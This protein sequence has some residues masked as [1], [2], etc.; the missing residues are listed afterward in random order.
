M[1]LL[2]L[3]FYFLSTNVLKKNSET[4]ICD[5]KADG[6]SFAIILL[7]LICKQAFDEEKCEDKS[8]RIP[9]VWASREYELK[10]NSGFQ[11]IDCPLVHESLK[12]E[13]V[14]FWLPTNYAVWTIAKENVLIY[15]KFISMCRV[16]NFS[17]GI[18]VW[19]VY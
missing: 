13:P 7:G 19:K 14:E 18:L 6:F 16:Y 3:Q 2:A 4:G 8:K 12:G 1:I 17:L 9:H 10:L 5:Q 15:R 11:P